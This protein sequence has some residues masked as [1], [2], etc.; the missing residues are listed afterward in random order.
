M[1]RQ[2]Q[3]QWQVQGLISCQGAIPTSS[4]GD[5]VQAFSLFD[6]GG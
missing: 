2:L 3:V 4:S 6:G 5:H 1:Y